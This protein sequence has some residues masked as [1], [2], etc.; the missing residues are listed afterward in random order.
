[1]ETTKKEQ[2]IDELAQLYKERDRLKKELQKVE[3]E[4][5]IRQLRNKI[6]KIK[7]RPLSKKYTLEDM[8]KYM[9]KD[10][11]FTH[12]TCN[13]VTVPNDKVDSLEDFIKTLL[14]E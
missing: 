5:E 11:P 9:P 14:K 2:K 10:N 8:F 13:T 6:D 7:E 1:M 12:V 4:E 3:L